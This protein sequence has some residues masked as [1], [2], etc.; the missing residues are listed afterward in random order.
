VLIN[1]TETSICVITSTSRK[2]VSGNE[3]QLK[4]RKNY[5]QMCVDFHHILL[6]LVNLEFDND[7]K[8][9]KAD[10]YCCYWNNWEGLVRDH[11]VIVIIEC[12][13]GHS[14]DIVTDECLHRCPQQLTV[15]ISPIH[16]V[17][18]RWSA[19]KKCG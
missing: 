2:L 4:E 17:W 5:S 9:Y 18:Y 19:D 10:V 7:T 16:M 3:E 14:D 6:P 11:V 13:S 1:K 12:R 15:N 8:E